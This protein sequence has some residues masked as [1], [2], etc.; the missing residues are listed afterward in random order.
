MVKF[1]IMCVRYGNDPNLWLYVTYYGEVFNYVGY[2][3]SEKQS[4]A[5]S[6]ELS[7]GWN[8]WHS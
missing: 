1:L 5:D 7:W 6:Y 3:K 2:S 8:Q 4:L